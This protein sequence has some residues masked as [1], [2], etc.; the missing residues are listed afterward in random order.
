MD[1]HRGLC[2]ACGSHGIAADRGQPT[3]CQ[4]AVA[5]PQPCTNELARIAHTGLLHPVFDGHILY[6]TQTIAMGSYIKMHLIPLRVI[7]LQTQCCCRLLRVP[8]VEYDGRKQ[9]WKSGVKIK[10]CRYLEATACAGVCTNL[11]KVAATFF[12]FFP[13]LA[14][15]HAHLPLTARRSKIVNSML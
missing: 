12:A 10:K 1:H 15:R 9:V 11:C 8:Q 14:F 13:F 7:L 6:R 2:L 4:Q 3:C 5:T